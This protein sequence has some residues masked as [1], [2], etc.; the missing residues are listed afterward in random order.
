MGSDELAI[1]FLGPLTCRELAPT[2]CTCNLHSL[3]PSLTNFPELPG[4][5]IMSWE[6]LL[7]LRGGQQR[8][9][10]G[11]QPIGPFVHEILHKSHCLFLRFQTPTPKVTVLSVS[12][13]LELSEWREEV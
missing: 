7:A 13:G 12:E 6:P 8:E 5:L 1:P 3:C 10:E 9:I 11:G 2:C 4:Q